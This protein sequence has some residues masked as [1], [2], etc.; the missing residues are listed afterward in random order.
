MTIM[1]VRRLDNFSE[2]A[3]REGEPIQFEWRYSFLSI[4][5]IVTFRLRQ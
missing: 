1:K 4:S 3:I 2:K 5:Y